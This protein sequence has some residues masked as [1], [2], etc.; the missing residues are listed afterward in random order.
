MNIFVLDSD[1]RRCARYHCDRHVVKMILESVQILCT[2]LNKRGLETPYRSTH[3]QHPCVLWVEASYD[4]FLWLAE[5][6]VELDREYRFRYRKHDSH[7]SIGVLETI[8]PFRYPSHGLTPFAQAMPDEY[9]MPG[10]AVQ[11]YRRF[12]RGEKMGFARWT[13]RDAPDWL[14]RVS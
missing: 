10:D 6:A 4:N 13:R 14:E 2:A 3:V 1:I 9:K 5:L 12:Y 11:A 7:S 8:L